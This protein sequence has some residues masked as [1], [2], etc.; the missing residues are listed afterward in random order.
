MNFDSLELRCLTQDIF[1]GDALAMARRL[2]ARKQQSF[3]SL[4]PVK[5]DITR[6][7]D[8]IAGCGQCYDARTNRRI[9]AGNGFDVLPW[10]RQLHED[11]VSRR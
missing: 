2:A 11:R 7:M 3:H 10:I 6:S 8:D 5:M 1:A 4:S 9:T